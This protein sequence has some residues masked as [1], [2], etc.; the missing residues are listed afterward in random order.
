METKTFK[1]PSIGCNGCVSTIVAE[2]K[3]LNGVKQVEGRV[4]TKQVTVTWD[5]PA[6]WEQIVNALTEIEYA[7]EA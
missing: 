6:T 5:S 1:V 3:T 7:P 2:L 4:D